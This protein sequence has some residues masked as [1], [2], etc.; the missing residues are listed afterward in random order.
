MESVITIQRKRPLTTQ[1]QQSTSYWRKTARGKLHKGQCGLVHTPGELIADDHGPV[2]VR[3]H[4]LRPASDFPQVPDHVPTYVCVDTNVVL[5]QIDLISSNYFPLPLLVAQTVLD[6]VRHRSLPL[7]N[8]LKALLDE[9]FTGDKAWLGKRGWT[10]WNEAIEETYLV[11]EP[12]ET[13][14][15]RNDRGEYS[16]L[17]KL[18]WPPEPTLT[19]DSVL[20]HSFSLCGR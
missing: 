6:E 11:K 13:P 20:A 10:V 8:K 19:T 2:V 7:Y 16:K 12:G 14:N 17:A 15:D 18:C 4:Y 9:D 3:E 5:H 1:G